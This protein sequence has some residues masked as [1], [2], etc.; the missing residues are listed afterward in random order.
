MQE[1]SAR[2]PHVLFILDSTSNTFSDTSQDKS[3]KPVEISGKQFSWQWWWTRVAW[4]TTQST[5]SKVLDSFQNALMKMKWKI[6]LAAWI[7]NW[8]QLNL[9]KDQ[10]Y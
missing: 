1:A 2:W 3:D 7:A 6:S 9:Q 10:K 4:A 8:R 5:F